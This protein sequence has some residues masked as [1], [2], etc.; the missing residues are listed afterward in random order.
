MFFYSAAGSKF[1]A[2]GPAKILILNQSKTI[3]FMSKMIFE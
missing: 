1:V 2:T 3:V